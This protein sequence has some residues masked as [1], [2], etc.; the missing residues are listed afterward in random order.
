MQ[1]IDFKDA[2]ESLVSN[3]SRYAGDAY[4]FLQEVL[5]QAVNKQRKD[6][7]GEDR[8]VSGEELLK[9]F[10]AR[11]KK[12]FGPMAVSVF[13]EWGINSCEDIGEIV[14][15]LITVGAFGKSEQDRRE[16]FSGGYDFKEAFVTPFLPVSKR[17]TESHSDSRRHQ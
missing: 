14:F 16:D 11:A 9:V 5:T 1:K 12:K 8:H 2:V 7:G 4:Y 15:N 13:E 6:T 10:R 17:G 3:D